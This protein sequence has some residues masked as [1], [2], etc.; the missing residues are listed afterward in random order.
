MPT[1]LTIP[2]DR[3]RFL[4]I[5]ILISLLF[6]PPITNLLQL[7]LVITILSSAD[8]RNRVGSTFKQPAVKW[9]LAFYLVIIAG[10]FYSIGSQKEIIGI[11]TGWRK[12]L[13]LPIALALF[14]DSRWK[15][16]ALNALIL[17]STLTA[18]VSF[19]LFALNI[20]IAKFSNEL[21]IIVRNHST[22]G[23]FFSIAAFSAITLLFFEKA[24]S[25]NRRLYLITCSILLIGNIALISTGRSGYVVL[26]ICCFTLLLTL[27]FYKKQTT[28]RV[29]LIT[30]LFFVAIVVTLAFSP[31]SHQRIN[32]AISELKNA[33]KATELT[34]MGIR[35]IFWANTIDLIKKQPIF[36]YGTGSFKTAY[37]EK[38]QGASGLAATSASDPH[39][40]YLKII[41]EHGFVGL[42]IFLAFLCSMLYLKPSLQYKV[43]AL[44]AAFAWMTTCL[45]NTH[46]STFSEG[47]FIYVWLGTM[48]ANEH[49]LS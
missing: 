43:L 22:Q 9:L 49:P 1:Y 20:P 16:N 13:L 30:T 29:K 34:S 47:T 2:L 46:F 10:T 19:L 28:K 44:G 31:T 14:D 7:L 25:F 6:S 45:A 18:S 39:N 26:L 38:I 27:I 32:Q 8:L 21:G 35:V 40:Q 15:L 23:M 12:I 3:A 4:V 36:G 5:A 41:A 37:S 17:V 33:P 42:S 11:A 48:L 24:S